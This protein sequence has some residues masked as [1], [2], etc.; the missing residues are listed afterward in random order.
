MKRSAGAVAGLLLSILGL[1]YSLMGIAMAY[2][3]AALP[4]QSAE[5]VR[6]NFVVWCSATSVCAVLV[7]VFGCAIARGKSGDEL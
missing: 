5:H 2:W 6:L 3:V 7:G 1:L 4:N